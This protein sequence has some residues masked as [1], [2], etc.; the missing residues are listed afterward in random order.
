MMNN[1]VNKLVVIGL[2]AAPIVIVASIKPTIKAY[3]A[4]KQKIHDR[5]L[6]KVLEESLTIESE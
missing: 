2:M 4:V 5:Q 3:Q 1:N 6:A